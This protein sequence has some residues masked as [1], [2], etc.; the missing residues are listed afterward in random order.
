MPIDQQ[1]LKHVAAFFPTSLGMGYGLNI[2]L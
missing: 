2:P 1:V